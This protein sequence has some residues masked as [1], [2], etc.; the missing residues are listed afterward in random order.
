MLIQNAIG[1][2]CSRYKADKFREEKL[3]LL[4]DFEITLTESEREIFNTLTSPRQIE[5]FV[6][7]IIK[8]RLV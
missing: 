1:I 6:K 2:Q 8:N 3:E 5:K 4:K 7:E